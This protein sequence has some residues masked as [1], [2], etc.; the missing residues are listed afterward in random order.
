MQAALESGSTVRAVFYVDGRG[1]EVSA[2]VAQADALGVPAFSVDER[3][4]ESLSQTRAPQGIV[5][6]VPFIDHPLDEL[7]ALVP[8]NSPTTVLVLHDIDDPGNAGTLLRSA[9]AFAVDAICIGPNSVDP[10]NDKVLRATMG[11][12][13]RV[14][15]VRYEGWEELVAALAPLGIRT[16]AAQAGASDIRSV[17]LPER[18]ALVLGN[19]RSGLRSLPENSIALQVG[20]PQAR[21]AESLNVAVAGSILLYEFARCGK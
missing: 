19:E 16:I 11:A 14:P 7:A 10:Y 2:A 13:F 9:E 8:A 18:R 1:A 6:Q 21:A 15:V 20:I 3:T 12:I 17:P 5:A 4:I